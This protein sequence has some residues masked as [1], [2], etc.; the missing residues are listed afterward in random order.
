MNTL[1]LLSGAS[2]VI[3][4]V[5]DPIAQ[6]KSPAGMT[7]GLMARGLNAVV[8]PFH[9]TPEDLTGFVAGISAARNLTG[10]IVTVPHKFAFYSLCASTSARSLLLRTVNVLRRRPDGGWHGDIFDGEGFVTSLI[11]GGGT[12]AGKRVLLVGAGG[13]GSAI[14]LALL[15]AGVAALAVHDDNPARR[16]AL[17]S[18]LAPAANGRTCPGS[19]DP[20]GFDIVVNATPAGMRADD[21]LPVDITRLSPAMVAADVITAPEE[22]PFLQAARAQGCRTRTGVEMFNGVCALMLDFYTPPGHQN[23]EA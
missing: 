14:A 10:L 21:P 12:P 5:G 18:L 6:V 19:A 22:T 13:A 23:R 8:V 3:G 17:L 1:S 4:I 20:T 2:A 7:A 15:E 16:A 9:V 11:A